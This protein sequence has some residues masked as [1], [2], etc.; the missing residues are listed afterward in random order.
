MSEN[1]IFVQIA[2]YR[3]P[4]LIPT[5]QDM[6]EHA[7]RPED[8]HICICW[9]HGDDETVEDF[10]NLGIDFD[11]AVL[12]GILV[13]SHINLGTKFTILDVNYFD[14]QGACWAR[15]QIQKQYTGEK[16]TLQLDSHHRFVDGW[17]DLCIEMLEQLREEDGVPKPVLTAYI[18]SF[19]PQN[20][21]AA[22]VQSPWKMDFDRFIPEG[23]VFFRPSTIDDWQER[24]KPM[25]SRFYSAHFCFA[26]GSFV[27]EVPHDPEYFFHGEEISIAVRAFTWGYDLF[28]PHKVV[29]W[30]E[31]TREGRTKVWDDH[32]TPNKDAGNIKL[33]WVE[34]NDICH[35]RNRILFGMDGEDPSQI[36]FGEFGFGNVR[37]VRQYEE[38]A[39]ISFQYRGVQ[40]KT[41][42]RVEPPNAEPYETEEEWKA[43]FA[44]SNDVHVCFHHSELGE[45][46]DDYD[47][48]YVGCHDADGNEI[49]RKDL[50]K[51]QIYDYINSPNGFFDYR[52]IFVSAHKP[53][54][55][56]VWAHSESRGWLTKIDKPVNY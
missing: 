51:Q 52:L 5:L 37:T 3:D 34:R 4:Q 23:A 29:A 14:A 39:G 38:Y 13:G 46:V 43:T 50:N 45:I 28:H 32:T 54:T 35:R 56:T 25:R 11:D 36:D 7:T 2:S 24:T 8:L 27:T 1:T 20:D 53:V 18:P 31:Y 42:D 22:R 33:D 16:Y 47:F 41:L 40:Q 44:S 6:L 49:E 15:Y 30:H 21:P 19:N 55:W 9:Q 26:D 12:E 10:E 17:D 48:F